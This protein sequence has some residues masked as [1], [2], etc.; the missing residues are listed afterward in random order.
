VC[1]CKGGVDMCSRVCVLVRE[2]VWERGRGGSV[3]VYE[4]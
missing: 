1:V 2:C 3:L 4:W